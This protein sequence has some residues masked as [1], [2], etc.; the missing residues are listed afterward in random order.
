KKVDAPLFAAGDRKVRIG[1]ESHSARGEVVIGVLEEFL[2]GRRKPINHLQLATVEFQS[3]N[4]VR[5]IRGPVIG[6]V[7][8]REEDIPGII[9]PRALSGHPD[10]AEA[11]NV[12]VIFVRFPGAVGGNAEGGD[13]LDGV[14]IGDIVSKYPPV[15]RS[16]IAMS[17]ERDK[18]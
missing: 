9:N 1:D 16:S 14:W 15:V 17:T 10:S 7:T 3:Q 6:A 5:K 12:N 4:A 2:V 11:F 18:E 8:S 13:L